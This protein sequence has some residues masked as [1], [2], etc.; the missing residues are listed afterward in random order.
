MNDSVDSQRSHQADSPAPTDFPELDSLERPETKESTAKTAEFYAS[1]RWSGPLPSPDIL[2]EYETIYPGAIQQLFNQ[3]REQVDHR[4]QMEREVVQASSKALLRG[5]W[6][7]Y[8]LVLGALERARIG[9]LVGFQ[10]F[11]HLMSLTVMIS[12]MA[13]QSCASRCWIRRSV[14]RRSCP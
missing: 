12:A 11:R 9:Y 14:L 8:T 5:Q 6:M 7:A 4:I 1:M 10:R 3:H 2:R 13:R